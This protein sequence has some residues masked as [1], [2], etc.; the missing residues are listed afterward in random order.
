MAYGELERLL[1]SLC[2][3]PR[4]AIKFRFRKLR[5]LPF[6]DE[7]RSGA[8]R[9]ILYD[10][11]RT[12]AIAS[13]FALNDFGVPQGTAV[14]LVEAAWPELCRALIAAAI[15]EGALKR[16]IGMP[17]DLP[18]DVGFAPG[19]LSRADGE[20]ASLVV[21]AYHAD[22][23]AAL[24]VD[25]RHLL[26]AIVRH[27]G[28]DAAA[29]DAGL[30]GSL[31]AL[32]RRFGWTAPDLPMRGLATDQ[33][34]HRIFLDEGPY[35]TRARALLAATPEQVAASAPRMARLQ[36]AMRYL[37]DPSPVDAWK[38]EVG[39]DASRP[40]LKHLLSFWGERLGLEGRHRFPA[41]METAAGERF[42]ARALDHLRRADG[43]GHLG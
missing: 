29:R 13:E 6:P 14:Q 37:D 21:V 30:G 32:E 40:R 35:F 26:Q 41:T 12:L 1:A 39:I 11:P 33:P 4:Q 23:P 16:S 43:A 17:I 19:A 3:A 8:G 31:E 5:L 36:A 27:L 38:A 42:R 2:D 20:A 28:G 10:L 9:R 34:R 22:A 18:T 25:C 15:A 24:S 7:I